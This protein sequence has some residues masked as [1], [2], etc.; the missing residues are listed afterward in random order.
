MSW[1]TN[2]EWLVR[3]SSDRINWTHLLRFLCQYREFRTR[4]VI[5][6]G[7]AGLASLT[8]FAIPFLFGIA[9]RAITSGSVKLIFASALGYCCLLLIQAMLQYRMVALSSRVSTSLNQRLILDYY[10]RLLNIPLDV[11]MEFKRAS[12]LFQRLIDAMSVTPQVMQVL[13]QGTQALVMVLVSI[14]VIGMISRSV[15]AVLFSGAIIMFVRVYTGADELRETRRRSLAVNYPLVANMM[16]VIDGILTVKALAAS[17]RVTN[18]VQKLTD[19]KKVAEHQETLCEAS[20]MKTTQATSS[21]I[22]AGAFSCILALLSTHRL[23]YSEAFALYVLVTA[24]LA[25]VADLAKFY[26]SVSSL[27]VNVSNYIQVLDLPEE[28]S[29]PNS[30]S[31]KLIFQEQDSGDGTASSERLTA[32]TTDL[33][34][35]SIDKANS[36]PPGHVLVEGLCFSY[37][38]QNSVLL[39]LDMEVHPG[40]HVSVIGRSGVGKTTLLRLLLAL[41]HPQ[42]GRILIDGLSF[43]QTCDPNSYRK[44]FGFVG[45][46]DCLFGVS[47][48]DNLQFG[49]RCS[50]SSSEMEDALRRVDMWSDVQRLP[51]GLDTTYSH[52]LLSGGQ[53]QR[54]IVARALL[55]RPKVVLLDEP[56]S[57]LDFRS[58]AIVM[59]AVSFLAAGRTTVTIAHRLSTVRASSRVLVLDNKR[60]V[61]SGSHDELRASNNYYQALCRYNSFII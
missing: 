30:D 46:Q 10:S 17:I 36:K 37:G 38:N 51:Q 61:A 39:D 53:R 49:L 1:I 28:F 22:L 52:D 4:A 59:N 60:I 26:Q 43:G 13:V 48:R 7:L 32:V 47:I 18:D 41:L 56:T 14:C 50:L 16:E 27:S 12:N 58:E 9:Q 35:R 2:N 8:F 31:T 40:E 44:Q 15:A 45:Q 25:P 20:L 6:A 54:L 29:L 24:A 19:A 21:V 3:R 5:S 33:N 55:R 11:F 23:Q 34:S 42:G 57:S